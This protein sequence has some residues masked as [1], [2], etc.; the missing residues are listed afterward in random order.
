M[1]LARVGNEP[2]CQTNEGGQEESESNVRR[3]VEGR[4][5]GMT[6]KDELVFFSHHDDVNVMCMYR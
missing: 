5:I 4:D 2:T 1:L 6:C 3:L